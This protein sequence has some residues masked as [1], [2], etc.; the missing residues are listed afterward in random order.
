M[1][2]LNTT[3][4]PTPRSSKKFSTLGVIGGDLAGYPNGR[5]IT[6]DVVTI[7][8]RAIAGITYP[9]V[10]PHYKVDPVAKVVT[11]GL[12]GKSV[13]NK[14]LPRFPYMGVPYDGYHHPS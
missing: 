14:P 11:D 9:L 2:R 4:P 3:I 5:R 13:Q 1:L 8:L 7:E 12:T 10:D 6:D